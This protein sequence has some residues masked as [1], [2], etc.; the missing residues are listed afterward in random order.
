MPIPESINDLSEIPEENSPQGGENI[1]G[2]LDDFL[3]VF[4]AI[5]KRDLALKK[6]ET[7]TGTSFTPAEGL[8]AKNVQ[9]ALAELSR[10]YNASNTEWNNTKDN[11]VTRN[12]SGF[13]TW[14]NQG[15]VVEFNSATSIS[16]FRGRHNGEMSWYVGAGSG[17][18]YDVYL[19]SYK[20]NT[21]LKLKSNE[22]EFSKAILINDSTPNAWSA[23]RLKTNQGYWRF[24]A[25]PDSHLP[26]EQRLNLVFTN[27]TANTQTFLRFPTTNNQEQYIAYQSWVNSRL[28]W[29]NIAGKPTTF[30]PSTHSHAWGE[31]T[32]KPTTFAPSTHTHPWSQVTGAP[33]TATRWPNFTEQGYTQSLSA[34]GWCK[35]PNGL[36]LQWVK[37]SK[38]TK[39]KWPIAFK[40]IFL[41]VDSHLSNG[42]GNFD[43]DL[44]YDNVGVWGRYQNEF[45]VIGIGI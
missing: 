20:H 43:T 31:I 19:K 15:E 36:I 22:V 35:L 2:T 6:A 16:A 18:S 24:E 32:G 45:R 38:A 21:E 39:V 9:G 26:T 33:A 25:S 28:Q 42:S 37:G 23:L 12:S 29:N 4:Q 30:A 34:A 11:I 7:A 3:R 10:K 41:A 44:F 40:K 13:I 5:M 14:K 17:L 8:A 27:T 1:G